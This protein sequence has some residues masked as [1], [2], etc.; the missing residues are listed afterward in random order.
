MTTID[1]WRRSCGLLARWQQAPDCPSAPRYLLSPFQIG[2]SSRFMSMMTKFVQSVV[3]LAAAIVP[4]PCR[5]NHRSLVVTGRPERDFTPELDNILRNQWT[6]SLQRL[7]SYFLLVKVKHAL[8]IM[9]KFFDEP[10]ELVLVDDDT[11]ASFH[12][13]FHWSSS[14]LLLVGRWSCLNMHA[15][16]GAVVVVVWE[17]VDEKNEV[18]LMRSVLAKSETVLWQ[19]GVLWLITTNK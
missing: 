13:L 16:V 11:A 5:K 9:P 12:N 1:L 19:W 10:R 4:F 14:L 7:A 17:S 15:Q 3:S 8:H 2:L 6:D 18:D